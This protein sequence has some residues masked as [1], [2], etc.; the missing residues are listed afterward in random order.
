ML[1]I[2]VL[3]FLRKCGYQVILF[4]VTYN[5]QTTSFVR[6]L[7]DSKTAKGQVEMDEMENRNGKQK[8]KTEME[9]RKGKAEIW[10]WSAEIQS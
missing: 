5:L 6:G 10:K 4:K 2:N 3:R 1:E 9:S 7:S 8:R